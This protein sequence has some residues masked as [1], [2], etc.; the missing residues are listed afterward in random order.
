MEHKLV[1]SGL[2]AD[3][4]RHWDEVLKLNG[5]EAV[6][7]PRAEG[8]DVLVPAF[9]FLA[10]K[11][12]FASPFEEE[13]ELPAMEGHPLPVATH[14]LAPEDRT[15]V[16]ART[17]DMFAAQRLAEILHQAGLHVTVDSSPSANMF[18][19]DGLPFW[20]ICIATKQRE[21]AFRVLEAFAR[22]NTRTFDEAVNVDP[23]EVVEALLLAPLGLVKVR[24]PRSGDDDNG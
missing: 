19:T 16:L 21:R 24:T 20:T 5:I 1:A 22:E 11:K 9:E 17:S 2:D 13:L 14:P 12:L 15:E 10:A 4:A 6:L 23:A 18:G 8:V 3:T 7:E